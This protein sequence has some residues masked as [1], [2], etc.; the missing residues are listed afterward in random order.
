MD[1]DIEQEYLSRMEMPNKVLEIFNDH[2]GEDRVDMQGFPTVNEFE[3]S[4]NTDFGH[5]YIL[6]HFPT[7]RI[8]NENGRFV[9]IN[10]LYAKVKV[11]SEGKLIGH[12]SL[13]RSSYTTSHI[14]SNYM[15]SHVSN[16]PIN[17]FKQFQPVCVGRGPIGYTSRTLNVDYNEYIWKLFCLELDKYVRVES[18]AGGPYHLLENIGILN[19]VYKEYY[20]IE[21]IKHIDTISIPLTEFIHY[22]ISKC[23]LKF[24]YKNGSYFIGMPTMEYILL[25]SNEFIKWYNYK[26]NQGML[27]TFY[28]QLILKNVLKNYI[29]ISERLYV[30][31]NNV[32][33]YSY[34]AN[35]EVCIFKGK[36]VY[37]DIIEDKAQI[38]NI[39]TILNV[40]ICMYILTLILKVVNLKYGRDKDSEESSKGI[41]YI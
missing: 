27:G 22:F 31:R 13:N 15:H 18:A 10:N 34:Y 7:V 11:T 32:K 4:I 36:Q 25:I 17:D 9:D 2:F 23:N 24:T 40:D 19:H 30:L 38:H 12:F 29:I 28:N 20:Y 5:G 39:S 14:Y 26:F 21:N 41:K 35:K 6:V 16:I 37:T 1:K 33:D 3:S 8:M